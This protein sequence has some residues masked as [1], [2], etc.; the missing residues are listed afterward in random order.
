M[1]KVGEAV[2]FKVGRKLHNGVILK[3]LK[4]DTEETK[5]YVVQVFDG[6]Q[7]HKLPYANYPIIVATE[8]RLMVDEDNDTLITSDIENEFSVN[9]VVC[10]NNQ[11]GYIVSGCGYHNRYTGYVVEVLNAGKPKRVVWSSGEMTKM[12]DKDME[13]Y[14]DILIKTRMWETKEDEEVIDY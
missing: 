4:P 3:E 10:N 13:E 6:K 7:L 2:L 14:F 11:V 5:K 12:S 8:D 1:F 9:D